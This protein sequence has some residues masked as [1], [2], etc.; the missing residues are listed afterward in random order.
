MYSS[1]LKPYNPRRSQSDVSLGSHSSNESGYGGSSPVFSRQ[2]SSSTITFNPEAAAVSFSVA[3]PTSHSSSLDNSQ[4]P[5]LMS[6]RL[7]PAQNDQS[8]RS[9]S[10]DSSFQTLSNH[11]DSPDSSQQNVTSRG[12]QPH[13]SCQSHMNNQDRLDSSEIDTRFSLNQSMP[14]PPQ[15]FSQS[16]APCNGRNQSESPH[17]RSGQ[18]DKGFNSVARRNREQR[19]P[20]Y[21]AEEFAVPEEEPD[22]HQVNT[23]KPYLIFDCGRDTCSGILHVVISQMI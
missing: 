19:K 18:S 20:L 21:H 7:F 14:G 3:P 13:T 8:S 6:S 15:Q 16:D 5:A 1:F 12:A 22:G 11:R 10:L 9:E 2:N 23:L 17:Q 4:D